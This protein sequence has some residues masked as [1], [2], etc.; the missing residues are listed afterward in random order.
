MRN[1]QIYCS[2]LLT[3]DNQPSSHRSH[4]SSNAKAVQY[5]QRRPSCLQSLQWK[6]RPYQPLHHPGATQGHKGRNHQSPSLQ[7]PRGMLRGAR[8]SWTRRRSQVLMMNSSSGERK[9][10]KETRI[11]SFSVRVKDTCGKS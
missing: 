8:S 1:C 2:L 6:V 10:R 9:D 7:Q 5:L 3:P 4:L 11:R